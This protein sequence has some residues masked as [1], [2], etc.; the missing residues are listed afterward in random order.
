MSESMGFPGLRLQ[1]GRAGFVIHPEKGW[2]SVWMDAWVS[3]PSANTASVANTW[4]NGP[5]ML[6]CEDRLLQLCDGKPQLRHAPA[7]KKNDINK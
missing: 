7:A 1:T 3:D 2:L 5:Y 6:P 4:V